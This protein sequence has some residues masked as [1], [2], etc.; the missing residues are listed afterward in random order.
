MKQK[1]DAL[2]DQEWNRLQKL[3]EYEKK[4]RKKGHQHIG[5]VD[6]AGRGPLAGPVV[7]A[8]C[9]IPEGHFFP[10]IDDSKKLPPKKRHQLFDALTNDPSVTYSIAQ[11][12]SEV[13]DQVNIYQATILAML[14]AVESLEKQPDCLLVDGMT[15]SHPVI[16][17]IKIVRGDSLSQSIA[18]ASILAKV[19]RDRLMEDFHQQWPHYGFNEH[20]GYGTPQHMEAIQKH[21]IVPI[22]RR[23]FEP[24]AI[25][26]NKTKK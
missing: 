24:V 19:T 9:V 21:G 15:L 7:A 16:P 23:S 25:V 3:I 17:S 10:G 5:G 4:A 13:I 12:D 14:K 20:K 11:I 2:S 1:P 18:A 8:V 26:A 22:H 6:E